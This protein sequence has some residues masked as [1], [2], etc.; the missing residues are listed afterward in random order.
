M[1]RL[2]S[3]IPEP[4]NHFRT[5]DPEQE[6]ADY[7]VLPGERRDPPGSRIARLLIGSVIFWAGFGLGWV[8][9]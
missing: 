4:K 5:A 7:H 1:T 3:I 9:G 2:D 6:W 8:V